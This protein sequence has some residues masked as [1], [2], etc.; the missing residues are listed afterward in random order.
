MNGG[1][2]P[3]STGLVVSNVPALI[4]TNNAIAG[5]DAGGSLTNVPTVTWNTEDAVARN[6][7]FTVTAATMQDNGN[8]PLAYSGVTTLNVNTQGGDDTVNVRDSGTSLATINADGGAGNNTINYETDSTGA[9]D[10]HVR[11]ETASSR[12]IYKVA[13][14]SSVDTTPVA[15]LVVWSNF[16]GRVIRTYGGNDDVQ[17]VTLAGSTPTD[18]RIETGDGN[19]LVSAGT[20]ND[21]ILGGDGDDALT[22]GIGNDTIYGDSIPDGTHAAGAGTGDDVI[23][24]GLGNDTLYAGGGSNQLSGQNGNDTLYSRNGVLDFL[25]GG[26]GNDAAQ[27]D[28][29]DRTSGIETFLA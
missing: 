1:G 16:S 13:T 26:I 23:F 18:F 22:G 2:T 10:D 8:Q 12:R 14:T 17:F 24:G 25:D 6:D 7:T 29:I 15:Q 28:A 27:V 11:Y 3:A 21:T 20:G 4:Y 19:D 5:F 9:A